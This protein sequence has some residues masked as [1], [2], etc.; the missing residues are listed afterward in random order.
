MARKDA[1]QQPG[2]LVLRIPARVPARE[3]QPRRRR[4]RPV[5]RLARLLELLA[6]VRAPAACSRRRELDAAV[7][8]RCGAGAVPPLPLCSDLESEAAVWGYAAAVVAA[9]AGVPAGG[10]DKWELAACVCEQRVDADRLVALCG[11]TDPRRAGEELAEEAPPR[12]PSE[13]GA[14]ASDSASDSDWDCVAWARWDDRALD[15]QLARLDEAMGD[16]F[17]E[18]EA[19]WEAE[20]T[21]AGGAAP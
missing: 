10:V 6:G 13:G 20:A 9:A 16:A 18:A 2:P 12:T 8:A 15:E 14:S 11:G 3:A 5:P 19:G 17:R 1:Q 4:L 21:M 7:A